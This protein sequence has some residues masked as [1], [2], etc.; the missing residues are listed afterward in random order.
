M[1][2]DGIL[3]EAE[4]LAKY[5]DLLDAEGTDSEKVRRMEQDA[6]IGLRPLMQTARIVRA[7]FREV[8]DRQ[9]PKK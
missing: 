2:D 8:A 1:N 5:L 6:P 3:Y 9:L 7:A 4:I